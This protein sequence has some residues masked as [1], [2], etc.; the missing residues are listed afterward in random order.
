MIAT[1]IAIKKQMSPLKKAAI[2]DGITH[3]TD[4][5]GLKFIL[6]MNPV[7][8]L[9]HAT[10]APDKGARILGINIIGLYIIGTPNTSGSLI[11]KKS[12][13]YELLM[14]SWASLRF[15]PL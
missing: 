12:N 14:I 6:L 8:T 4:T 1:T 15:D 7:L 11:L 10:R 9:I 13:S 2:G 5:A 3:A